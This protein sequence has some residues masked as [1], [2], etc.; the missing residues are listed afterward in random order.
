MTEGTPAERIAGH[1]ADLTE[2]RNALAVRASAG[3]GCRDALLIV[4]ALL[5]VLSLVQQVGTAAEALQRH[6]MIGGIIKQF[7][8]G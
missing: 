6:P 4:D 8:L 1:I 5:D 2:L 7:G 3:E